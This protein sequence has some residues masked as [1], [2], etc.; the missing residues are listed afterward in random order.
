MRRARGTQRKPRIVTWQTVQVCL[1][2][3][4]WRGA[5]SRINAFCC[6]NSWDLRFYSSHNICLSNSSAIQCFSQRQVTTDRNHDNFFFI[7]NLNDLIL[8][9]LGPVLGWQEWTAWSQ[10]SHSCGRG[11][12]MRARGCIGTCEGNSTETKNC[13]VSECRGDVFLLKFFL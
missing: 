11:L 5:E 8:F 6:M 1:K 12:Q 10:C 2:N 9:C 3:D 4:S 7:W 13:L